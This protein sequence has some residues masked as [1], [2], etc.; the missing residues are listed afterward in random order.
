MLLNRQ[1]GSG[2]GQDFGCL[3]RLHYS[4]I[5]RSRAKNLLLLLSRTR[6]NGTTA[7]AAEVDLLHL[8]SALRYGC[9]LTEARELVLLPGS[10][11]CKLLRSVFDVCFSTAAERKKLL[12]SMQI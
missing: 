2:G 7:N 1:L 6:E 5:S 12:L 8:L 11:C 4:S 3:K 9:Q 10:Q